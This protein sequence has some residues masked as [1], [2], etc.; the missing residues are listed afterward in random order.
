MNIVSDSPLMKSL[1]VHARRY[2]ASSATVLILGESGT[3]KELIARFLHQHSSRKSRPCVRVN[4]AA[5]NEGLAE[6]ELFGHEQGAFTGAVRQHEGCISAAGNGT[7][8]LDEIAELPLTIQAKLLRALEENE[9]SRVGSTRLLRMQAR[10]IAATNR[11]LEHEVRQER[12][13]AD[14][15]HRLD[16]LTLRVPP[17]RERPQDIPGLVALFLHQF[18]NESP[19]SVRAVSPSVMDELQAFPWPGNIRQLRNVIHRSCVVADAPV[20]RKVN[21]PPVDTSSTAESVPQ[22]FLGLPLREIER[23]VILARLEHFQ[24]NK[25]D[26]AAELGVSARTLRNKLA[27]YRRE[28]KA[29]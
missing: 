28:R 23:R 15:F 24:G 29:A 10:V 6:S 7:L 14:L 8:V 25:T 1:L 5:F 27:L 20:I 22:A 3:G 9:F 19:A 21:L 13:R 11:D 26:A 12:F 16:V 17:L 4:C 2:A 18:R